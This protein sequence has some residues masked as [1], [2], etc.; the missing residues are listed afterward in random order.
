MAIAKQL[1][2]LQELDSKIE[3]ATQT[4][5]KLTAQ[6]GDNSAITAV[7]ADLDSAN[8][9]LAELRTQQKSNEWDDQDLVNKIKTE[10]T[11]LYDGSVVN[12]KELTAIQNEVKALKNRRA[13]SEEKVLKT[14]EQIAA[15]EAQVTSSQTKL[16]ELQAA[17]QGNQ[18]KLADEH[19]QAKA[20][21][22][23]LQ[24]ER[25]LIASK[26]ARETIELYDRLRRS[27]KVAVVRASQ[28][29]CTGCRITLSSMEVQR[30]RGEK[31]VQCSSCGRIIYVS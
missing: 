16:T 27:K 2:Q 26:I 3:A 25:H 28:G 15:T 8:Q 31:V 20:T 11:R 21:L 6:L 14:L 9:Q 29:R 17:W 4:L 23:D 19:G 13:V 7:Q 12:S 30:A 18:Q 5:A 22:A 24:N 1:F 10:E